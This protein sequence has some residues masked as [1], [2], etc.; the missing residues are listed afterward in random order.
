MRWSMQELQRYAYACVTIKV[1]W[2]IRRCR[3]PQDTN[4]Q[5]ETVDT[6][7]IGPAN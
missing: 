2:R 6:E 3:M 1:V 7:K 5:E 4:V